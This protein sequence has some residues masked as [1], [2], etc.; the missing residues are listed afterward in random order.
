MRLSRRQLLNAALVAALAPL[1]TGALGAGA[2]RADEPTT[3]LN[4]SYDVAREVFEAV[5]AQ[6]V[7]AYKTKTGKELTIK[8]S[9]AGTSK[10]AR[11]IVEGLDADVVT[12][13]QIT[14][15]QFLVDKGFVAKD[16]QGR[17]PNASSP[18]YSFPAFLVRK[19]NPK[20]IKN[21]DDLVR[22]DVKLV[23][24]NPKTS[25]NAR[26][27]YLAA[28]AFALETFKGDTT[29]ADAFAK[30]LLGNVVVF[31][32]GGRAATTSFVDR[33][34]G[35]VLITFESEVLGVRDAYKD[36]GFE[37]VVP[38]VSLLAEFP[39]SVVDKVV[40]KRGSRQIATDYLTFL[41]SPEGQKVAAQFNNRVVDAKVAEEFKAKFVPVRL[42]KVEDA[43]GSWANVQ[44]EHFASGGKLDTLFVAQ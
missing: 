24:P 17:L 18:W 32:T 37:V 13:N 1:V 9:H 41:Y 10:Q 20:G 35:D 36:K 39:V 2:A 25:G 22:D 42:L 40:D 26:Y 38:P 33:E 4:A 34:Q 15:I 43:L 14:D 7:P 44:K 11:S 12:F 23:F 6:F 28:Y 31:D 19:G 16:W 21:W 29:K 5:N 3:L 30:K 27:T 8:Q